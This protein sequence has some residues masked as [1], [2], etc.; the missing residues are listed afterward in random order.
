MVAD[1]SR[2]AQKLAAQK[3]KKLSRRVDAGDYNKS[4]EDFMRP[5][6]ARLA[7][8]ATVSCVVS[9]SGTEPTLT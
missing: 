3:N 9:L 8:L 5:F 7:M 2:C 6:S 4:W 1:I